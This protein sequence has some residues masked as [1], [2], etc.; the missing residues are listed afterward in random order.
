MP[1]FDTVPLAVPPDFELAGTVD[2]RLDPE[3]PWAVGIA[4][5]LAPFH[6]TRHLHPVARHDVLHAGSLGAALEIGQ[7]LAQKVPVYTARGRC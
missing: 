1:P 2:H 7:H 4:L 5:E 3:P 6:Q